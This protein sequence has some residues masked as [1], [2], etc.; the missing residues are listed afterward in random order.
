MNQVLAIIISM[1][2]AGIF[3]GIVIGSFRISTNNELRKFILTKK[4][5]IILSIVCFIGLLG[6]VYALSKNQFIYYWDYSGYWTKSYT[7]T[8]LL[9]NDPI[10][11]LIDLY[12]S[13]VSGDY[14]LLLPTIIS[15]PIKVLGNTF[16]RYVYINYLMFAIPVLLLMLSLAL[17]IRS[18][19]ERLTE[20]DFWIALVVSATFTLLLLPVLR[21]YIDIAAVLCSCSVM[22]LIVDFNPLVRS[23]RQL[24]LSALIGLN[25][26]CAFVCRRYFAFF[27]VGT[28]GSLL[29]MTAV[30]IYK[31]RGQHEIG[32]VIKNCFIN[33]LVMAISS[34]GVLILLFPGLLIRSIGNRYDQ[35]YSAYSIDLGI[36]MIRLAQRFGIL[37]LALAAAGIVSSVVN[38]K[39]RHIGLLSAASILVTCIAFLSVQTIDL[40]HTYTIVAQVFVLMTL[41]VFYLASLTRGICRS[42][43]LA[44]MTI[45]LAIQ[46]IVFFSGQSYRLPSIVALMFGQDFTPLRRYDIPVLHK[47]A[48][49]VNQNNIGSEPVYVLASSQVLNDDI[50][51]S[52]DKPNSTPLKGLLGSSNI[53]VRDGFP[54]S[55]WMQNT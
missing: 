22:L 45:L 55:F 8:S 39:Y 31:E 10:R 27:A 19:S 21:G 43:V 37:S 46:P 47:I 11:A 36:S 30:Q 2:L 41:G 29:L 17:K 52:L 1:A 23:R 20:K 16:N 33:Y 9:F 26:A 48:D 6:C 24:A 53:D 5:I 14:N 50:M 54:C 38:A 18:K 12:K 3:Y 34:G 51:M 25:M 15:L 13:I 49:Y 40:Q 44:I 35:M 28:V 7:Q 4:H 42:Y 32:A